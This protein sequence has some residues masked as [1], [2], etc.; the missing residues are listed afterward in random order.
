M[1]VNFNSNEWVLQTK[2]AYNSNIAQL[3]G[4]PAIASVYGIKSCSP[5]HVLKYFHVIDGLPPDLAHDLFEGI[6]IDILSQIIELFV[7]HK[8]FTLDSLNKKIENFEYSHSHKTNKPRPF[9]VISLLSFKI[10]Q[11]A[12]EMWNLIRLLPLMIGYEINEGNKVWYC[13]IKFF[14]LVEILCAPS[15]TFKE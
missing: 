8:A 15:L 10:K 3:E 4:D 11:T 9:K 2:E 14:Q 7:I 5:L 1:L 13:Y 12:C 6:A